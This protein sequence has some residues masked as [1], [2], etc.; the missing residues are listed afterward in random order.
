MAVAQKQRS[1]GDTVTYKILH[2]S[3]LHLDTSFA[4][5]GFSL[6]YGVE[7]RLDLRA[8]LTKILARARDLKVDTVTIG[9]D[10]FDHEYLLPETAEF[11]K[12]QFALLAPIRVIIAPGGKDPYMS[13]SSYA[14]LNWS[15]N[16]DIFYQRKLTCLE[17][18]AD[19]HI[20]GACN[21]PPFGN[22]LFD[23][24]KPANGVNILLL[25]GLHSINNN[26]VYYINNEV[27][28]NV[29]FTFALLGGEHV[30]NNY[31]ANQSICIYPGTPEPLNQSEENG[32]H[33]IVAIDITGQDYVS[34][35][36]EIQQW[37]YR[38]VQLDIT[39]HSSNEETARQISNLLEKEKQKVHR[40]AISVEL[41]GHAQ[42]DLD[43]SAL[44]ELIQSNVF[45]RLESHISMNY[46]IEQLSHEQTVRGLLVKNFQE[47][48]NRA[49]T[50]FEHNQELTA[51]NIALQ[52]LEG[53]QVSLYEIKEN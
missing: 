47:R 45:Y 39:K 53:K 52:A 34:Q 43:F 7:R 8:C 26:D 19:I 11:I 49:K 17:L 18:S 48:I 51:L 21:P 30:A 41:K 14:R 32:L 38:E 27:V 22:K 31:P 28:K 1:K 16:V 44:R 5:Q 29:G 24:F 37:H 4:G 10:L 20:W 50:E 40:S 35:S 12:Q 42:F 6:G 15:D 3:D 36:Y 33:Q 13:D 25:H 9:G 2:F 23:D 46:D